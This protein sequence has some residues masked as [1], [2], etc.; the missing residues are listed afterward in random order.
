MSLVAARRGIPL[1]TALGI[2][3]TAYASGADPGV[4]ARLQACAALMASDA[5]LACYDALAK[6]LAPRQDAVASTAPAHDSPPAVSAATPAAPPPESFGSYRAEHPVVTVAGPPSLTARVT[7]VSTG[8]TGRPQITLAGGAVWEFLDEGDAL[9]A[10]GDEV[11]IRR[12]SFKSFILSTPSRREH[13]VRRV[14]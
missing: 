14:Q 6:S 8:S 2:A 1:V 4:G 10:S 11:T 5:R 3:L 12:A 13:R 7:A 9:L